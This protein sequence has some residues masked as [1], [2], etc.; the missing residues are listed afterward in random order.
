[1]ARANSYQSL[2][3]TASEDLTSFS[4]QPIIRHPGDSV[5][6]S[7]DNVRHPSDNGRYPAEN[8][9]IRHLGNTTR[10]LSETVIHR[11]DIMR[12]PSDNVRH[13]NTFL[14][15]SSENIRNSDDNGHRSSDDLRYE[16]DHRHPGNGICHYSEKT[17]HHSDST[18]ELN[19]RG[20]PNKYN[21]YRG[22]PGSMED[23]NS[24]FLS[25]GNPSQYE[26]TICQPQIR[27]PNADKSFM[28]H[29]DANMT[30]RGPGS[31]G[32]GGLRRR[33][34]PN[35]HGNLGVVHRASSERNEALHRRWGSGDQNGRGEAVEVYSD[36]RQSDVRQPRPP[37]RGMRG[38]LLCSNFVVLLT[39]TPQ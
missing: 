19:H 13:P 14:H 1:M 15:N 3:S 18:D 7:T 10:R 29:G 26:T 11:G 35:N 2:N 21:N 20:K 9:N 32:G 30:C 39:F 22:R 27:S 28:D 23:I 37:E 36:I 31:G 33:Y 17:V 5:R 24:S 16:N 12:H 25:R 6:H 38:E 4:H 8:T 34:Q